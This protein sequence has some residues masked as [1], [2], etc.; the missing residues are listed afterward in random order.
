M[1]ESLLFPV[2]IWCQILSY[3]DENSLRNLSA[4][5]KLFYGI[6][7][8][9]EKYSGHII[10]KQI[11]LRQFLTKVENGEWNWKRWPCLKTLEIPH[12]VKTDL[13][14]HCKTGH[15]NH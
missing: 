12:M 6:I 4:T 3:L 10:L 13:H 9:D 7:R 11:N 8:N 5:N 1:A 15:H 14:I 2:E